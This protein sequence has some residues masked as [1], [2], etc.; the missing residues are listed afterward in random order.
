MRRYGHLAS[1]APVGIAALAARLFASTQLRLMLVS[2]EAKGV[3]V[4]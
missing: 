1:P 2:E 3:A 4:A